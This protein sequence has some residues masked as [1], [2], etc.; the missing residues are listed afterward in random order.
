MA[1]PSRLEEIAA[2]FDAEQDVV[3]GIWFGT[4]CLKAGGKVFVVQREGDLAL[5]L[6][7]KAH[8]EALAVEGAHLFD[9]QRKGHLMKAWVQVPAAQSAMW[10]RFAQ[11]A[12]RWVVEAAA[13][14]KEELIADL[15][16]TRS[17]LL[18][19]ATSLPAPQ[20]DQV[21]LGVWSVKDLLAHLVGWDYANLE[22]VKAILAGKLPAFYAH[23]DRDWQT[24]NARLVAEYKK[25]DLS[26]LDAS[27]AASHRQLLDYVRTI[28]AEA[29]DE[30]R[31][32]RFKGYKVTIGRTLQYEADDEKVHLDQITSFAA[33]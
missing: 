26:E 10:P 5:K 14:R 27:L 17:R 23:H 25:D 31:G 4:P 7:G 22:A 20:Q 16:D 32:V 13:M 29:F 6:K 15:A 9:P 33:S 1:E 11:M 8:A 24:F 2:Q 21:F 3:Q 12:Y 18:A 19:A 30:D 28:P